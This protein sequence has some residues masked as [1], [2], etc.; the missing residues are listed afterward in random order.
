MRYILFFVCLSLSIHSN[1]LFAQQ[2]ANANALKYKIIYDDPN[3]LR[4]LFVHFQPIYADLA[5][6]NVTGGFGVEADYLHKNLFDI[7]FAARTTYGKRFDISRDAASRNGINDKSPV[8]HFMIDLIGT[9]HIKDFNKNSKSKVLLYSKRI[10]GRD[11]S[12]TVAKHA[13]IDSQ[14]RQIIGG[15]LGVAYYTTTTDL[16]RALS[17]QNKE[18]LHSDGSPVLD[19]GLYTNV[20]AFMIGLGGSMSW[21]RNYSV[22][23]ES[24]WDPAGDDLL[25]TSYF[26]F[27][28]APSVI[29]D[30]LS[31]AGET[32]N[33]NPIETTSVGFRAGVSGKFNRNLSWGY[34]AELGR[35]PGLKKRGFFFTV[36]MSFPL[37]GTK[38]DQKV[39]AVKSETK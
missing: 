14:V 9:Y 37:Y 2:T 33:S 27:L 25:I 21:Y 26:D 7:T 15:R 8:V 3:D 12:S 22:E 32:I 5:A 28:L 24:R 17:D 38:L 31:I 36:K 6:I 11:W 19:D 29:V 4:R 20:K 16:N 18:L 30:N 13:V 39:A 10:K 23:F 35:R 1:Q 34:G